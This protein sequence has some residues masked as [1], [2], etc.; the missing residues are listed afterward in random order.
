[1][2]NFCVVM[3]LYRTAHV[4]ITISVLYLISHTVYKSNALNF[5]FVIFIEPHT[6]GSCPESTDQTPADQNPAVVALSAV[7]AIV[8]LLLAVA[9]LTIILL[10]TSESDVEVSVRVTYMHTCCACVCVN[11]CLLGNVTI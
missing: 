10:Y 8:V 4:R 2:A 5:L 9:I 1:M 6:T 3:Y 7:L 11:V